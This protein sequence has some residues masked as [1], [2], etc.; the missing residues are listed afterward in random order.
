M[1]YFGIKEHSIKG[2]YVTH[3]NIEEYLKASNRSFELEFLGPSVLGHSIKSV[4]LGTGRIRVLMWSQMHGNESTTTKS[5]LDFLNFLN[6]GTEQAVKIL[7]NCTVKIIPMLNPD[8]AARYTRINAN[9]V[10]LNRDAQNLSQPESV[11]LRRT[12][13]DFKP[14]YCFNLHDQRTIFNVGSSP[15]PATASFLAPASDPKR[16]ISKSRKKSMQLIGAIQLQLNTYIP[17]Q[18]GRYNDTYNPN[19]VGDTFQALGTPTVLFEAG[20]FPGDYEREKTREFIFYALVSALE[21]IAENTHLDLDLSHYTDIPENNKLFFDILIRHL[22]AVDPSFRN[23]NS[24]GLVY[25]EELKDGEIH[26]R[27]KIEMAG[28]LTDHFGHQTYDC[29]NPKDL[30]ALEQQTFWKDVKP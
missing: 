12:Y 25:Q 8:G 1:D 27:P 9:E 22:D 4:T 24:V 14:H 17:G 21:T 28:D 15:K 23:K 26:F 2:R 16:S 7:K 13:D 11:V 3:R 6:T 10:D 30:T 29:R 5:V 18:I 20:H 19:C